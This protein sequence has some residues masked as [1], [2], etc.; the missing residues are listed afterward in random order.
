MAEQVTDVRSSAVV[1]FAHIKSYMRYLSEPPL[2]RRFL[3]GRRP[4]GNLRLTVEA[5]RTEDASR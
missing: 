5:R 2:V 3:G 4:G 1:D